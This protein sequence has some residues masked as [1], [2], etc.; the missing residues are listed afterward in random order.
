M[1]RYDF[2]FEGEE[3]PRVTIFSEMLGG[4]GAI[5]LDRKQL[6][7]VLQK[8]ELYQGVER[9]LPDGSL[10]R[11]RALPS[12]APTSEAAPLPA[13]ITKKPRPVLEVTHNGV[14]LRE[15][16]G[17]AQGESLKTTIWLLALVGISDFLLGASV[18]DQIGFS[19]PLFTGAAFSL[20]ALGLWKR[21]PAAAILGLGVAVADLII[22]LSRF[23]ST[24]SAMWGV[25]ARAVLVLWMWRA[26]NTLKPSDNEPQI[27]TD[28]R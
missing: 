20:C 7:T 26:Y 11:A 28:G 19:R 25:V 3:K 24:G 9:T 16:V 1:N 18:Y 13:P 21:L 6:G 10:L 17:H 23:S 12:D 8:G 22:N 27:N 14:P 15:V 2:A 4:G 5:S